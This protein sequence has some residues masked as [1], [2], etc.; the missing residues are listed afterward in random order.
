MKKKDQLK[1]AVLLIIIVGGLFFVSEIKPSS[2]NFSEQSKQVVNQNGLNLILDQGSFYANQNITGSVLVPQGSQIDLS[3][4]CTG[5]PQQGASSCRQF[6]NQ[7]IGI[8]LNDQRIGGIEAVQQC[9]SNNSYCH[10]NGQYDYSSNTFSSSGCGSN[11]AS[12]LST[13]ERR[14]IN[15]VLPANIQEKGGVYE[16]RLAKDAQAWACSLGNGD[17][18]FQCSRTDFS[19]TNLNQFFR[20]QNYSP[21]IQD[22]WGN[23]ITRGTATARNSNDPL[24]SQIMLRTQIYI[25]P[26]KCIDS[27]LVTYEQVAKSGTTLRVTPQNANEVGFRI[28]NLTFCHSAPILKMKTD[29]NM[30]FEQSSREYDS[31]VAGSYVTVPAGEEWIIFYRG[32]SGLNDV[33]VCANNNGV[34]NQT[35][36]RCELPPT[37]WFVC[38]G[39]L[40]Q[41]KDCVVQTTDYRCQDPRAILE[42]KEDNSQVCTIYFPQITITPDANYECPENF[43]L[44]ETDTGNKICKQVPETTYTCPFGAQLSTLSDDSKKCEFSPEIICNGRLEGDKCVIDAPVAEG[45]VGNQTLSIVLVIVI[46]ISIVGL[47]LWT[48][49]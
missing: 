49:K 28:Q 16:L 48:K 26:S 31:L 25:E 39:V 10:G 13:V 27:S 45:Q 1:F 21:S 33:L 15:I 37:L 40:T 30:V 2:F 35:E 46:V 17:S 41:T 5:V 18:L 24:D 47:F 34:W 36:N 23:G 43:F 7:N 38:N 42:I 29:T 11:S 3:V 4:A 22:Y 9:S 20:T 8:Y 19:S 32:D 12:C 44:D 6:A 14:E